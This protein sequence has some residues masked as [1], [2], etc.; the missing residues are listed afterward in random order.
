MNGNKKTGTFLAEADWELLERICRAAD[1]P[2]EIVV[3]MLMAENKVYG[4]GRRHGIH[5]KLEELIAE[6]LRL[7]AAKGGAA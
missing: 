1:V 3:E 5:E 2:P 7:V 4:M 6:G